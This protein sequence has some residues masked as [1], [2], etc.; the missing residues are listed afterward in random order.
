MWSTSWCMLHLATNRLLSH[1]LTKSTPVSSVS[2]MKP[3][4]PRKGVAMEIH[5]PTYA[6]TSAWC[7]ARKDLK[8]R[9]PME[10]VTTFTFFPVVS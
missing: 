6:S 8:S 1:P 9:P 2:M 5:L 10:C 4:A 7:R 3:G